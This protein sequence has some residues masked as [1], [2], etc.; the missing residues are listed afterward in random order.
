MKTD[1]SGAQQHGPAEAALSRL[2]VVR[3]RLLGLQA[4]ALD[5]AAAVDA[6]NL[7]D[8]AAAAVDVA[9]FANGA[10][11]DLRDASAA[12][13]QAFIAAGVKFVPTGSEATRAQLRKSGRHG[14]FPPYGWRYCGPRL[15][16]SAGEQR[17]L[18]RLTGLVA[19]GE[20]PTAMAQTLNA[21]GYLTRRR[22]PWT[23]AAVAKLVTRHVR[24]KKAPAFD[25][26][27]ETS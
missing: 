13:A 16:V 5:L 19:A 25:A 12:V 9:R 24:K 4:S 15:V 23:C 17:V 1:G 6:E 27:A 8:A 10:V 22:N 11:E 7:T 18:T 26:K 2:V 14:G 21:E 20:G 3:A